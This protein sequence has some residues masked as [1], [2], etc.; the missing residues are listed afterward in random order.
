[1]ME[2]WMWVLLLFLISQRLA[3]LILAK[4]NEQWMKNQGAIEVGKDHYKWFV[5]VHSFFFI[6]LI[7]ES[8]HFNETATFSL[9]YF[10]LFVITQLIRFWCIA[11]LG[12]YWN[13]KIIVLPGAKLIKKGPY[14][15]IKHPNYIIVGLE[16]IIIPLLFGAYMT[17]FIFIT[18]HL[19][20][21]RTRI[22]I[23]EEALGRTS[24]I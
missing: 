22:P 8:M 19:I 7:L 9:I 10:S 24:K 18:L 16:L 6:S 2:D 11:T 13:T 15:Y 23:E 5:L 14:R 21:L 12:R 20:L 17:A 3:E 4:Q 1:M